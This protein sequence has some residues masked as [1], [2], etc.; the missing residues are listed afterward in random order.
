MDLPARRRL[1]HPEPEEHAASA[2]SDSGHQPD[3]PG[4]CRPAAVI[5][6]AAAD[7]Q[8]TQAEAKQIRARWEELKTVTEGFVAC[9][10]E[11]NF[12]HIRNHAAKHAAA[13][14]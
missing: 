13:S 4:I 12:S 14:Q 9:C 6:T 2:L 11:G 5:A 7:D 1:F 8:I 10:E 3:C